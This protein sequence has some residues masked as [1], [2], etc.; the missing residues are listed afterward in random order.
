M[1]QALKNEQIELLKSEAEANFNA[2]RWEDSA[3]TYEHLVGLAQKNNDFEQAIDFALAAI[4]AWRRMPGKESRINKLY[5]AV[6]LIG[7]K[8][9][10]IGFEQVAEQA[11]KANDLN[12]AAVNFE[13]AANGY[14]LIQS[15]ERAKAAYLKAIQLFDIRVKTALENK[16]FES[17][18]H[19]LSRIS[20]IYLNLKKLI[21]YVLI[22]RRSSLQKSE[23]EAL[24]K[25]KEHYRSKYHKTVVKIAETHEKL[26][27]EFCKQKTA[28]YY[29]IAKKELQKAIEILESIDETQAAK[30]LK[31]K[32][33]KI[34][35]K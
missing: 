7:L 11:E 27:E 1:A 8:K 35:K 20:S 2:S 32:L 28:D 22:E 26:S 10:A 3:K 19:L 21:N 9:A 25:E 15:F 23:K 33:N 16:D 17:A 30:K 31:S 5:Q 29:L 4:H 12:T 13:E 34:P 18:I 14:K 24:F 6:G